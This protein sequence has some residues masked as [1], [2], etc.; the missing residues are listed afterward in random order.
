MQRGPLPWVASSGALGLNRL[1]L[2]IEDGDYTIHLVFL[3]PESIEAGERV[4]DVSLQGQRVESDLDVAQAAGG[5][6]RS[7]V[8]SYQVKSQDG[9]IVIELASKT[10]RPT[11]LSGVELIAK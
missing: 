8:K 9:K 2:E 6:R 7:I 5:V 10:P 3:E 11:V 4:F 1:T